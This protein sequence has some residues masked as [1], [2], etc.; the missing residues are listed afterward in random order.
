MTIS[1]DK[2]STLPEILE[3]LKGIPEVQG[4]GEEPPVSTISPNLLEKAKAVPR[5]NNRI[6]KTVF[7]TLDKN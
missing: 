7:L 1:L 6:R 2:T 4:A 3:I 5:V